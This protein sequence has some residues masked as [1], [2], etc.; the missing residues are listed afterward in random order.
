MGS[1]PFSSHNDDI[2]EPYAQDDAVTG[3]LLAGPAAGVTPQRTSC[4]PEALR[5]IADALPQLVWIAD[6]HGEHQYFNPQWREYTQSPAPDRTAFL[7]AVH[8]DDTDR[9]LTGWQQALA[10]GIDYDVEFRLINGSGI[11]RWF[12][13]RAH[14][15]RLS[16]SSGIDFWIGTCTDVDDQK[17]AE[18]DLRRAEREVQLAHEREHRIAEQ[19]QA[20]LTPAIPESIPG[21]SLKEY[22]RAGLGEANV[23]GD[24]CDVYS[25]R[26]G[27]YALVVGDV[28][29]KGL[30]AA[31]QVSALRNM[32]RYALFRSRTL[33][34]AIEQLNIMLTT[35][36]LLQG[37]A[38]MFV[39]LY[40][41]ERRTLTYVSCG[42]EP[43]LL[44][45]AK[46]GSLIELGACGPPLCVS[47]IATYQQEVVSLH[48]GDRLLIY[49]DGLS[50]A[51]TGPSLLLGSQGI[52]SVLQS[53]PGT[54]T[55]AEIVE[56]MVTHAEA[57]NGSAFRDDVCL[58][59][60]V[61][62]P[63]A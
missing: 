5:I 28:A 22:Y 49:T 14:P 30:A 51:G 60:G 24:F 21:L 47:E 9:V 45:R 23:G 2:V 52:G 15:V 7:G 33:S 50:E 19:L 29:G 3:D 11:P 57:H 59:A 10:E 63:I 25:V 36:E 27:V 20:A 1:S 8:A 54:V 58:L 41:T 13:G 16:P 61:V 53:L 18:N 46:D 31:T 12:F 26:S 4:S 43:V 62:T 42:H 34:G 38:S 44:H 17:R 40:N 35:Q 55:P 32:V 39:G 48:P 56:R 6:A 37:F